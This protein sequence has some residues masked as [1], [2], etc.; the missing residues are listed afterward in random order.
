MEEYSAC[1]IGS[2]RLG[3]GDEPLPFVIDLI[4]SMSEGGVSFFEFT[5]F[6]TMLLFVVFCELEPSLIGRFI[7]TELSST[8][9][10][11]RKPVESG[12]INNK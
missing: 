1:D 12:I 3:V 5:L 7:A 9:F 2:G 11:N 6:G 4:I 10:E 8:L